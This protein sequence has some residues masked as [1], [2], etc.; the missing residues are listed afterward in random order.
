MLGGGTGGAASILVKLGAN[1]I[2][3][4]IFPEMLAIWRTKLRHWVREPPTE[5]AE[6]GSVPD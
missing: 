1:P 3:V 5:V 4:D 6:A 2:V